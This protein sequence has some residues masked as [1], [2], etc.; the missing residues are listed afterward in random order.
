MPFLTARW[1]NLCLVTY[2][3]PPGFL[4]DR[5]PR[6]LE[7]D[8]REGQAFVSLVAFDFLDTRVL[9][10]AWP[11]Y[12]NFAEINLRYYVRTAGDE[13]GV[14]FVREFVPHRVVA[15][16]ARLL[17]NEPYQ[18]ALVSS[19]LSD[20]PSQLT[21]DYRLTWRGRTYR[22]AVTGRKP[23]HD[24]AADS[25]EHFFKEHHWGFGVDRR[26]QLI[27]YAVEHPVWQIYPV[28]SVELDWDWGAIYGPEWELLR[29]R[30]PY[31]TIFAV[32]SPV[33]VYRKREVPELAWAA[34]PA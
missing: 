30:T 25:V 26:G 32:G 29:G 21:A 31:S 16:L 10:V 13:R 12:R 22:L 27:R 2:A 15:W 24:V 9:G 19:Q 11:G 14:V 28:Q 3:V 33:A 5:V 8:L 1:S 6:G 20:S 23:A 18:A 4:H 17:Y 7:L 34:S